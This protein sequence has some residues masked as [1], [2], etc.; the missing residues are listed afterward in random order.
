MQ[1]TRRI[2]HSINS[3]YISIIVEDYELPAFWAHPQMTHTFP[4][5]VVVHDNWGLTQQVRTCVRRLAET[6]FYV[7]AP[8]LYDGKPPQSEQEA[9]EKA[10]ELGESGIPRVSAALGVL[11]N[12]NHCNGKIG[13]IG[14]QMG[15]ELALNLSVYRQDLLAA[16]IFYARP[17]D[18]LPMLAA[19]EAPLLGFYGDSDPKI[20]RDMVQRMGEAVA[21][22]PGG[23][24]VILYSGVGAEFFNESLP[25]YNADAT[26]DAWERMI[27]FLS[28]KLEPPQRRGIRPI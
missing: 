28:K 19:E 2:Q 9:I 3:G 23:G 17:D 10:A 7:I 13:I 24:Q 11:K 26:A 6:G 18:Y 16:V 5:L 8:D 4:G 25:T 22:S 15:G 27:A 14:W 12:H 1:E 21:Q 20:P